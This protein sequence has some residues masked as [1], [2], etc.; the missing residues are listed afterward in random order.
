MILFFKI[1]VFLVLKGH[2]CFEKERKKEKKK[3]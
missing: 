2:F 1:F 3:D